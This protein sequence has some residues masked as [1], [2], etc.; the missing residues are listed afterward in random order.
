MFAAERVSTLPERKADENA[1]AVN[2]IGRVSKAR[3]RAYKEIKS[4]WPPSI[5]RPFSDSRASRCPRPRF[6][7]RRDG[8]IPIGNG[9]DR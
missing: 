8:N 3:T 7:W 6:D 4:T 5:L 2:N 1:L 9:D